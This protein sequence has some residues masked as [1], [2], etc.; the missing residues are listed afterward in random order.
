MNFL[1]EDF[2]TKIDVDGTVYKINWDYKSCINIMIML[3]D[4]KISKIKRMFLMIELL[5][6]VTVEEISDLKI[7]MEKAILFLNCGDEERLGKE[8]SFKAFDWEIDSPYIYSAIN[9]VSNNSL[10]KKEKLHWWEFYN[11]FYE[12]Q[13]SS[14][15][16]KLISLRT[17]KHK[18]TLNKEEK[19]FVDENPQLFL[20]V[21][22]ELTEEEQQAM[23]KFEDIISRG[24]N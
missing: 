8:V 4:E 12:I 15:I 24:G 7:A 17:K 14:F 13:E 2:P 5:Y 18:N 9:Q 22:E 6:G 23:K 21:V 3:S 19:I 11:Y 16:H 1:L 20:K 10:K